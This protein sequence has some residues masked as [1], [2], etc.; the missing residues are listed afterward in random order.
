MGQYNAPSNK[1]WV[2]GHRAGVNFNSGSPVP[3][4][5]AIRIY[6]GCASVSNSSGSLLF[7]TD[8]Q[9]IFNRL[10]NVMPSSPGTV[11]TSGFRDNATQNAL[12]VPVVGNTNRYYVFWVAPG[13]G[14]LKYWTVDMTLAGGLGDVVG[15]AVTI[16]SGYTEKLIAIQGTN[17]NLWVMA[18][19]FASDQFKAYEINSTGVNTT[20]VISSLGIVHGGTTF[21]AG[22]MKVSHD[23]KKIVAVDYNDYGIELFD[24]DGN[25][26]IVSN[27]RTIDALTN[28]Y[29]AEFSPDNSK[30]YVL[31]PSNAIYQYDVSLTTLAAIQASRNKI[32]NVFS[33]SDM[34]LGPDNK[35]YFSSVSVGWA[36]SLDCISLPNLYGGACNY[37][38]NVVSFPTDSAARGFPNI[39]VAPVAQP[40]AIAGSASIC[41]GHTSTLTNSV[42]GGVWSSGAPSIATVGSVSGIVV[43]VTAGT[44]NITYTSASGCKATQTV[45]VIPTPFT[46]VITGPSVVCTGNTISLSDATPGGSWSSSAA[47]AIVNVSTGVVTG[48]SAGAAVI[49]YTVANP[50]GT[51]VATKTITIN[52]SPP[53][54]IIATGVTVCI[55]NTITMAATPAG[56]TWSTATGSATVIAG[57]VTGVIAGTDTIRYTINTSCGPVTA[58][59]AIY[60]D[61]LPDPGTVS[62]P[63][64]VCVGATVVL[65]NSVSGGVWNTSDAAIATVA[66]GVVTGIGIGNAVISYTVSNGCGFSHVSKTITVYPLPNAGVING[67]STLC[68]GA[69][70]R[71]METVSGGVW[72]SGSP[73]I[74]GIDGSTGMGTAHDLGIAIITYAIGPDANGC[75]NIKTFELTVTAPLYS[76][77]S[78]VSNVK[79]N[80]DSS[81]SIQ[82]NV[83]GSSGPFQYIWSNG[84]SSLLSDELPVGT[85]T[86]QLKELPTQCLTTASYTITAPDSVSVAAD[87]NNDLCLRSNGRIQIHTNGGVAPYTYQWSNNGTTALQEQLAAGS[88]DVTITDGNGCIKNRV[89][90]VGEDT[91]EVIVVSD[92]I[93]PN[94]DGINDVWVITGI[95]DY[96]ANMVQVFNKWGDLL[97]EQYNYN[98]DWNG[99]GITGPLADGT[100]FYIVKLNDVNVAGGSN[101][102]T[103]SILIKR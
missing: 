51:A 69:V 58:S 21:G 67:P 75:S 98:N 10:G 28:G 11:F 23:G 35:I 80:G 29:G 78:T 9:A 76:V 45:T 47:T 36:Q 74:V 70:L 24:F 81:G 88:Y 20:P 7:Y 25:T 17:C 37:V 59:Q 19:M 64:G 97:Y 46:A 77:T 27:A 38:P 49:S 1:V 18:H 34:K 103:G 92:V 87:I 2:F 14:P 4:T 6:E 85:Y 60:V 66:A 61:E 16:G 71:Y 91:C 100:Y 93:T 56:G 8:G 62:G 32:L 54:A 13:G 83:S 53:V 52:A 44:A 95:K 3:F 48:V 79:C 30:L 33:F 5:S 96:P 86:L 65:G 63:P 89:F 31:S 73:S 15:A 68:K 41:Q 39:V 50:C 84:D 26:G 101:L 40:T 42:A 90:T 82:I 102:F 22:V 55:G 99:T 57:V 72:S 94:G 43:G 12:I